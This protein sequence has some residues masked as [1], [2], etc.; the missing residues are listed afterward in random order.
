M[1]SRRPAASSACGSVHHARLS[2]KAHAPPSELDC[3]T[4]A[5]RYIQGV[6][7]EPRPRRDARRVCAT[8]SRRGI[9]TMSSHS[10][11]AQLRTQGPGGAWIYLALPAEVADALGTAEKIEVQGTIN[12]H[13]F[14]TSI[15]PNAEGSHHLMIDRAMRAGA[16]AGVGDDVE[17]VL[18]PDTTVYELVIPEDLI[19]A[20][21]VEP[22]VSEGFE[23]LTEVQRTRFVH[24]INGARLVETRRT[25]IA[26]TVD[27]LRLGQ[28]K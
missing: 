6:C 21:Q 27:M 3:T 18:E 25:R 28:T 8:G 7:S 2:R 10:F 15:S 22:E 16:T 26:K 9:I 13:P 20:V 11:T 4:G 14:R 24:W 23:R 1:G 19:E 17:V 5:P 12:G